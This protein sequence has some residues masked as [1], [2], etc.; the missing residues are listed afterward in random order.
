MSFGRSLVVGFLA[1]LSGL[2]VNI[3]TNPA[4][5]LAARFRL[6]LVPSLVGALLF[7]VLISA[8]LQILPAR[9]G[10]APRQLQAQLAQHREALRQLRARCLSG[11][12]WTASCIELW[13]EHQRSI[14]V[15]KRAFSDLGVPVKDDPIDSE[16]PPRLNLRMRLALIIKNTVTLLVIPLVACS[17][18]Y[19]AATTWL[20]YE[21][22]MPGWRH[23][24]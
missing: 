20:D 4:S 23:G 15:L 24:Q 17:A 14:L 8:V 21:I 11:Q 18:T 12:S 6:P 1:V 13:Q 16:P 3:L 5:E 9:V 7:V 10:G 19:V 22:S 2:L